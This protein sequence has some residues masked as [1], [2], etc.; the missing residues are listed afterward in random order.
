MPRISQQRSFGLIF[1]YRTCDIFKYIFR[2]HIG[3][4]ISSVKV[5]TMGYDCC[6]TQSSC[7]TQ[8]S[9]LTKEEKIEMLREYKDA[10]VKE[11]Q[12]VDE[13]IKDLQKAG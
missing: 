3:Y 7:G 5:S 6:G 1:V 9:F 2:L 4:P 10:L 13:R 8:R 12:G 11:T